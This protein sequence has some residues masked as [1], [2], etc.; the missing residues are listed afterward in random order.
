MLFGSW[1]VYGGWQQDQ[2]WWG[3]GGDKLTLFAAATFVLHRPPFLNSKHVPVPQRRHDR[4][5]QGDGKVL[6]SSGNGSCELGQ[7]LVSLDLELGKGIDRR[8]LEDADGVVKVRSNRGLP[9]RSQRRKERSPSQATEQEANL[10]GRLVD[11]VRVDSAQGLGSLLNAATL[12]GIVRLLTPGKHVLL[13]VKDK[14]VGRSVNQG[15]EEVGQERPILLDRKV[16]VHL[17]R[18]SAVPAKA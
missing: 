7:R 4:L 6:E 18:K 11:S 5:D 12:F 8:R 15:G 16:G 17:T 10:L 2:L 14:A 3:R 1:R 13:G 9:S